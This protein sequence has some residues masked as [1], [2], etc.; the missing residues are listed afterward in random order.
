MDIITV[1][2]WAYPT[3][4]S[5]FYS[6]NKYIHQLY[7]PNSIDIP[8]DFESIFGDLT[9]FGLGLFSVLFDSLFIVQHYILYRLVIGIHFIRFLHLQGCSIPTMYCVAVFVLRRLAT[10]LLHAFIQNII[11]ITQ[12]FRR[13]IH[14]TSTH[15]Q[16]N[17]HQI[18]SSLHQ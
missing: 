15:P 7:W 12:L 2:F 17:M 11:H 8:D 6:T 4:H 13:S 3:Y 18:L 9:K 16:P 5:H 14:F 10:H 1:T